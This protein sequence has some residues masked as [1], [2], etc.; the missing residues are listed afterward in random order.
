MGA[1]QIY[2]INLINKI[3]QIIIINII[4]NLNRK[5]PN[6]QIINFINFIRT[7]YII[8][9]YYFETNNNNIIFK[10]IYLFIFI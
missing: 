10:I 5:Y 8:C 3:Y 6:P 7:Y 1:I 4:K 9:I 2:K